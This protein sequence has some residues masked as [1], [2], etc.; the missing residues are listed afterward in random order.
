MM[1]NLFS[2]FDP[3]TNNFFSMNWMSMILLLMYFPFMY[4]MMPSNFN[5]MMMN[6]IKILMNEMKNIYKKKINYKNCFMMISLFMLLF[7]NNF[8]S[9]FP[10]IFPC[11]SHLSISLS[12]SMIMWMTIMM[13]TI[14]KNKKKMF[15]H[16]TPQGTPNLLMSFMVLIET[17]SIL[18]RP[19]TLAIRLSAN[20]ISGHLLLTLISNSINNITLFMMLIISIQSL[21][22]ILELA[23]SMIQSYVF[24]ILITLYASETNN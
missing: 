12:L 7:L 22:M 9:L 15:I 14:L 5:M 6:I 21:L 10:Y 16:L 19:T 2:I 18:I 1:T 23:I 24:S 11:N 17:I 8:L 4:W 3:S 20:I 13:F